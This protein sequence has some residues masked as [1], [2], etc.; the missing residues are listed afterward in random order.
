MNEM[1]KLMNESSALVPAV[2]T[3]NLNRVHLQRSIFTHEWLMHQ[4]PELV[5]NYLSGR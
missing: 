5:I 3:L 4:N 2:F 1:E